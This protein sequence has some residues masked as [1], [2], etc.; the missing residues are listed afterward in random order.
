MASFMG[1][2]REASGEKKPQEEDSKPSKVS[3][4]TKESVWIMETEPHGRSVTKKPGNDNQNN[5]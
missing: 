4:P 3:E 1:E 5:E 2:T